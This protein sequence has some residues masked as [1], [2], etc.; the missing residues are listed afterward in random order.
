MSKSH[1]HLRSLLGQVGRV[2]RV[3][4]L[5]QPTKAKFK[6]AS[7]IQTA[8]VEWLWPD[9]IPVGALTLLEGDPGHGKSTV[10]Y[11]IAACVSA[12]LAVPFRDS[13]IE[14]AGVVLVQGE[15]DLESKVVPS[16]RAAGADLYR[17]ALIDSL[18]LP[19]DLAQVELAVGAVAAR[20]VVIDPITAFF[21]ASL[22]NDQSARKVLT[23]L[24]EMAKRRRLAVVL[25]RH[26]RKAGGSAEHQGAG[27]IGIIG[28]ARS[29]LRVED[30]PQERPFTHRLVNFKANLSRGAPVCYRT[31]K[32]SAGVFTVEWS[33][34]VAFSP[35][36]ARR[37]KM[38]GAE[39]FLYRV[40]GNGPMMS[41]EVFRLAEANSL[42]RKTVERA[43]RKL[44][45]K[46]WK[47]GHGK[48]TRTFWGLPRPQLGICCET[49]LA[50]G[51]LLRMA[52]VAGTNQHPRVVVDNNQVRVV[53]IHLDG[54][55][56][57]QIE[58]NAVKQG[59][60][61]EATDGQES[62]T[63][64]AADPALWDKFRPVMKGFG[65]TWADDEYAPLT[66]KHD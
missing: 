62:V 44:R 10:T 52:V 66:C 16:L 37:S 54:R 61:I 14:P 43:K 42:A 47:E 39:D 4:Q 57:L 60:R 38:R 12:G 36:S 31:V 3:D 25:L 63:F 46:D 15:D 30:D 18:V 24:Q 51:E 11:D 22:N 2:D 48:T 17:I 65:L 21:G 1:P 9:R 59:G 35:G 26:Y 33:A 23:P 13:T 34:P 20:L 45:I 8:A 41:N 29:G 7:E 49:A 19:D 28:A 40:L 32:V 56:I 58:V 55:P 6:K 27:S 5:G 64:E 53:R 50:L